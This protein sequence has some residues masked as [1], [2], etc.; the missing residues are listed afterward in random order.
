MPP[1]AGPGLFVYLNDLQVSPYSALVK[2]ELPEGKHTLELRGEDLGQPL[3]VEVEVR[4]GQ[5]TEIE[6]PAVL[7]P[8]RR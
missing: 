2:I 8:A 5:V 3:P 1:G 7:L 4:P 6:P